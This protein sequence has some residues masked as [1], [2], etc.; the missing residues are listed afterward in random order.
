V[1]ARKSI[2]GLSFLYRSTVQ[3][4]GARRQVVESIASFKSPFLM[5]VFRG[6]RFLILLACVI[7]LI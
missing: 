2:A 1:E 7:F 6:V 4:R 5:A 3:F